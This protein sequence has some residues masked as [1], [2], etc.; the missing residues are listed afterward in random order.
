MRILY[1]VQGTGNGHLS[2]ARLI[3]EALSQTDLDVDYLLSGRERDRYF[4]MEIFRDFQCLPGL[5]FAT[6]RGKIKRTATVLGNKWSRFIRDVQ[7]LEVDQYDLIITDYEPISAWAARK[8]KR[9]AIG[10]G[11]QYAFGPNVPQVQGARTEKLI[12]KWFAPVQASIGLHWHPY[13]TNTLPPVVD[14][15]LDASKVREDATKVLV[16]LPFE[17]PKKVEQLLRRFP[18]YTFYIYG[19]YVM[20]ER[21]DNIMRRATSKTGFQLDLQESSAVIANAGFA[22]SSEALQL[23]KRLLVKAVSG[24]IEQEGNVLALEDLNLAQSFSQL[25]TYTIEHFLRSGKASQQAYPNVAEHIAA[26]ISDH[27]AL[28]QT[29]KRPLIDQ[30]IQRLSKELWA[31]CSTNARKSEAF[32]RG[33]D[34]IGHEEIETGKIL[35]SS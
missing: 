23:G 2:R 19:H 15:Q 21:S 30:S 5:S 17:D 31:A 6:K 18:R 9:F 22:L 13:T 14:T 35:T 26:W 1:G 10:I 27:R 24:Q 33:H 11:H 25:S 4:D 20:D 7:A 8:A 29:E 28:L 12:M 3:A 34:I 32:Q 16:Y